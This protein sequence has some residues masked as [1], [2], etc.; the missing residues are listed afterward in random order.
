MEEI[1]NKRDFTQ[2]HFEL[3]DGKF[4]LEAHIGHI[5]YFDKLDSERFREIDFGLQFDDN[6]RGWFFNYH[7]FRPFLPEYADG[8]VEFRDLFEGK[9]Q[10][11]RYRAQCEH[12]KGELVD[13]IKGLTDTNAVI[14]SDAF[15]KG[16]D[17][18]LY[19]TR[20]TLKK[21]VR[22]RE[23]FKKVDSDLTFNFELGLPKDEA[24]K[25]LSVYRAD[26]REDIAE[27][28]ASAYKLDLTKDKIFDT[29]K[30]LLIGNDK[31]DGKEW[32]TYMR[33]FSAWDSEGLK[34]KIDVKYYNDGEKRYL[35]KIVTLDFLN[36]SVGDVFTDTTT[37]YYPGAGD[38]W[39]YALESSGVSFSDLMSTNG[40]GATTTDASETIWYFRSY[41]S[42]NNWDYIRRSHF[43]FTTSDIDDGATI[44]SATFK[45]YGYGKGDFSSIAPDVGLYEST[46]G[47]SA[48]TSSDHNSLGTTLLAPAISYSSYSTTGY[49]T[50][51]LNATGL[52][53]INKSGTTKLA[54][55]NSNYENRGGTPTAP[56]WSASNHL[57]M[58]ARY[59]EYSGTSQD[60][61]L[62]VTYSAGA[63]TFVPQI[64]MI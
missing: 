24:T 18:I 32:Y 58:Q 22:I 4:K 12:V 28:T 6:R 47:A 5:H 51:T 31:A 61:V 15:G 59:S 54:I 56:T 37:S 50:F 30:Q 52:S 57:Y 60:P 14:Y 36:K 46:M 21:V 45:V 10:T 53:K 39:T 13:S 55:T 34:E 17:Y 40:D 29:A 43:P 7:S 9:D 23:E 16:Y 38:G 41:S 44:T 26:K 2:K 48:P 49:N 33:T 62:E 8:W 35:Q 25:E 11:T 20:S 1:L 63:S 42:T 64:I 3:G 27:L 19:F